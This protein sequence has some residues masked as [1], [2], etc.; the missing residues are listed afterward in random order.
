M[1]ALR[2]LLLLAGV[3]ACATAVIMIKQRPASM[4]PVLLAS[5]RLFVAA[6]ALT[7]FLVRDYLRHRGRFRLGDLKATLLPGAM[8]GLH[9]VTWIIGA[10]KP[11][12]ANVTCSAQK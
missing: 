5:L 6:V 1:F 11:P 2:I 9:F 10:E 3:A 7:P 4:H 8:L 12:S